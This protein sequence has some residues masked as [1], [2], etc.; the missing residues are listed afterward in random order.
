MELDTC[1]RCFLRKQEVNGLKNSDK[2]TGTINRLQGTRRPQRANM[3]FSRRLYL[4]IL[5]TEVKHMSVRCETVAFLL[6]QVQVL[7]RRKCWQA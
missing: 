5:L 6:G 7:Q 2:E 4:I 3:H 1:G